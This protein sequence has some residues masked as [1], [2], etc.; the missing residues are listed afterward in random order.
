MRRKRSLGHILYKAVVGWFAD[1]SNYASSNNWAARKT[2]EVEHKS[3]NSNV[4]QLSFLSVGL[5]QKRF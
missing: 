4:A 2:V 5:G 1:R 3:S